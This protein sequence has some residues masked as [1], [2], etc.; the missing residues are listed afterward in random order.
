LNVIPAWR[1]CLS[2]EFLFDQVVAYALE[3]LDAPVDQITYSGAPGSIASQAIPDNNVLRINRLSVDVGAA[4]KRG[5]ILLSGIPESQVL[6]NA[7]TAG[8]Q[9]GVLATLLTALA[10]PAV[11]LPGSTDWAPAVQWTPRSGYIREANV[12]V[13]AGANTTFTIT[14]GDFVTE[15]FSSPGRVSISG[16]RPVTGTYELVSVAAQQI[17]VVGDVGFQGVVSKELTFN[18]QGTPQTNLVGAWAANPILKTLKRRRTRW[19]GASA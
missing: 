10:S 2:N 12:N 19:E 17:V 8:F 6:G 4:R 16:F 18:Q 14:D 9:G 7:V 15:G 13:S 5:F 11:G 3:D 1:A